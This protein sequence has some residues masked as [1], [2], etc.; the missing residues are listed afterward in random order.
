MSN[1]IYF[2]GSI[3]GGREDA[4]LYG[5]IIEYL[6]NYGEVLTEHIGDKTLSAN[7]EA[8]KTSEFIHD[9]DMGWIADSNVLV[10]EITQ[11]S[12]GVGYEIG[13]V[14]ERNSWVPETAQKRILCLYR[15]SINRQFSLLQWGCGGFS[16]AEYGS[17]T[18]AREIIYNF[19]DVSSFPIKKRFGDRVE[20][21]LSRKGKIIA[22]VSTVR[23]DLGYYIGWQVERN[24]WVPE[25]ERKK[26]LCL[27]RPHEGKKLSAMIAGCKDVTNVEYQ[28]L[29]DATRIMDDFV[30]N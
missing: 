27:Y 25:E 12:L 17:V 23:M 13:R 22:D 16:P 21:S 9:R 28:N 1:K 2:A 4:D 30:G 20:G 6:K 7:G 10:S 18:G 29:A 19:M 24:L 26:I 5:Q 8:N 14:V 11:P 15:P 3:R